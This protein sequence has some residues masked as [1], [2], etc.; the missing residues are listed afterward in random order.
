MKRIVVA[1]VCFTLILACSTEENYCS[2]NTDDNAGNLINTENLEEQVSASNN[3]PEQ[4]DDQ[5]RELSRIPTDVF[6]ECMY[7][8]IPEYPDSARDCGIE[9]SVLV[10]LYLDSIGNIIEVEIYRSS[11]SDILDQAAID[12]AWRSKWTP[13]QRTGVGVSVWTS[14]Y[15]EF[16]HPE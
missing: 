4:N 8:P 2:E 15:Y 10:S 5:A 3:I 11:G 16:V 1:V 9:G 12:A 6:P 13:A 7:R 14:V